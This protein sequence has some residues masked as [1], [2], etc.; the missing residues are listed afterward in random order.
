MKLWEV[1][2]VGKVGQ[3]YKCRSIEHSWDGKI[4]ELHKTDSGY[5]ITEYGKTSLLELCATVID[6][7]WILHPRHV[8][9]EEAMNALAGGKDIRVECVGMNPQEYS[10]AHQTILDTIVRDG[11][12]N[13]EWSRPKYH[14]SYE[15]I[16]N[17]SWCIV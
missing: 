7:D 16:M 6:A 8:S 2:K 13:K 17:G 3:R 10:I 15:Q 14:F 12:G 4:Y 5:C 1:L 9:F 11:S